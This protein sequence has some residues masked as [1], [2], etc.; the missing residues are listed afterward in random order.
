[1]VDWDRKTGEIR[2][3]SH[4]PE[5][6][7]ELPLDEVEQLTL[8]PKD[9][10]DFVYEHAGYYI[11]AT[12]K[13]V[14]GVFYAAEHSNYGRGWMMLERDGKLRGIVS[15]WSL[16]NPVALELRNGSVSGSG[17]TE[18]RFDIA[19]KYPTPSIFSLEDPIEYRTEWCAQGPLN[20][21]EPV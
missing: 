2:M 9:S 4:Q 8:L 5:P 1:M 19:E 6:Y 15:S 21:S 3:G 17:K 20:V 7:H 14:E 13:G 16:E 11:Q 18:S 12:V 10:T